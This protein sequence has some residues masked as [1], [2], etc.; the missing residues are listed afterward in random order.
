MEKLILALVFAAKRLRSTAVK[1]H[2]LRFSHRKPETRYC[3]PPGAKSN[4]QNAGSYPRNDRHAWMGRRRPYL[5]N[6]E[7]WNSR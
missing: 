5:T 1:G 4:S 2:I 7:G 6:P 3:P